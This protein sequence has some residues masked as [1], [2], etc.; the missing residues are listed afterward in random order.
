MQNIFNLTSD[1]AI[2]SILTLVDTT[3][4]ASLHLIITN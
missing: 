3:L 4:I 2:I 1:D